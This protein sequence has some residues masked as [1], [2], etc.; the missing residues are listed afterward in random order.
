MAAMAAVAAMAAR[1]PFRFVI[2]FNQ[3]CRWTATV[4]REPVPVPAG[5][6]VKGPVRR[7]PF[8]L[9]HIPLRLAHLFFLFSFRPSPALSHF[10]FSPFV[11]RLSSFVFR[12]LL[13]ALLC[14]ANKKATL[15]RY[16]Y[17]A[18]PPLK[19]LW[20]MNRWRMNRWRMN[21]WRMDRW[22]MDRWRMDRWRMNAT[23][24]R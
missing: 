6:R 3:C 10:R 17:F 23:P 22:R 15:L 2:A 8:T 1:E 19:A 7:R 14:D 12:L 20:R 16:F 24:D 13:D 11:F 4:A 21:R 5:R 9:G 18:V